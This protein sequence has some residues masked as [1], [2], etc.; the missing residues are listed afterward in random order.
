MTPSWR[1]NDIMQTSTHIEAL[2]ADLSAIA[3]TGDEASAAVAERLIRAL[4][5]SLRLHLLEALTE[6][7]AEIDPQLPTGRIDVRL[8]G[9]DVILTYVD[10]PAA[11]APPDQD[12]DQAARITLRLPE[13]LKVATESAAATDG[14][15]VNAW[16]L[17]AIKASLDRR[18]AGRRLQGYARS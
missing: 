14:L 18:P 9:H 11:S 1:H 5:P 7:A 2:A 15:S 10:A 6:A 8:S 4:E 3:A 13:R 12:D 17:R 16:L